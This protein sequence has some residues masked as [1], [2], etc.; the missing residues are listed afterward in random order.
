[1][2]Q[3]FLK[4]RRGLTLLELLLFS[5]IFAVVII[6]F[7]TVL[8]VV[9]GVQSRQYSVAEVNQQSQFLLQRV[10]YY[11]E[12]SSLID[13]PADAPT[14]VLTLRTSADTENP[15]IISLSGGVV[16]LKVGVATEQALTSDKV[17][18]SGLAFTK[19]SNPPAK[20]S[21]DVVFTVEYNTQ[22]IKQKF[23]KSLRTAIARVNAASFDSD[24]VPSLPATHKL[25]A[26]GQTWTAINDII[27]FSGA[28]VGIGVTPNA[29]LQVSGGDVFVDTIGRG[30]VL[31]SSDGACWRITPSTAGALTIASLVCP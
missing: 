22:N 2:K 25:G 4:S 26:S 6:G 14:N 15:T 29:K 11:V 17:T 24:V 12:R 21:V 13:M 19:R 18:V 9:A 7:I 16:R 1:M 5:G 31:R 27:N 28:N 23:V 8:V 10:Q 20:D 30:I 3:I